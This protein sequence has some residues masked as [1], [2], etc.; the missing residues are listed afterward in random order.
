MDQAT[1]H[2]LVPPQQATAHR[3]VSHTV[4]R[5]PASWVTAADG[6]SGLPTTTATLTSLSFAI[7]AVGLHSVP[8]VLLRRDLDHKGQRCETEQENCILGKVTLHNL[9][10]AQLHKK[11]ISSEVV[12]FV[13][14]P[15]SVTY[16]LLVGI[17]LFC[18]L[19]AA[20]EKKTLRKQEKH[21][22]PL[23]AGLGPDNS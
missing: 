21:N 1:R 19:S 15:S 22:E 6:G 8:R 12:V 18:V 4:R 13:P 9:I 20:G 3:E 10:S 5:R 2:C 17:L 11:S 23:Q 7:P 16:E 14:S